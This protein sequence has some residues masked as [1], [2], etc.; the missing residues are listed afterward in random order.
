MEAA[1]AKDFTPGA[2]AKIAIPADGLN[3]DIHG[4]TEY[5]AHLAGVMAKRAVQAALG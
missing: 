5:R 1:L 4:S 2:I 3:S